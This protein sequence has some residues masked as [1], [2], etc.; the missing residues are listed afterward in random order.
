M[1]HAARSP[2]RSRPARASTAGAIGALTV[3]SGSSRVG[4]WA[5]VDCGCA[6]A[7]RW[8]RWAAVAVVVIVV[9]WSGAGLVVAA[10]AESPVP[11]LEPIDALLAWQV[12]PN[13]MSLMCLMLLLRSIR[14]HPWITRPRRS[15]NAHSASLILEGLSDARQRALRLA[16][17]KIA[18]NAGWDTELLKLELGELA[19]LDVDL[20]ATGFSTSEIDVTLKG[21]PDPGGAEDPAPGDIWVFGDHRIGCGEGRD[22]AFLQA[23]IGEGVTVDA[24]FL[25][26]PYN[27]RISGHANARG[28]DREFA[29]AVRLME[30]CHIQIELVFQ[31]ETSS[32][33]RIRFLIINFDLFCVG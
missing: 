21:S 10:T 18:L 6:R 13:R 23:V 27:V 1:R 9:S 8:G 31:L 16:D 22:A 30:L 14:L 32:Q 12:Q 20:S 15:P 29:T 2:V 25:D 28:R 4:G 11:G 7:L 24:A 26:P 33:T 19:A 5:G 17:N 3:A